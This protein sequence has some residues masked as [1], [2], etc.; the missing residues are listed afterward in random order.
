MAEI[1]QSAPAVAHTLLLPFDHCGSHL[2]DTTIEQSSR[3]QDSSA[4]T[5]PARSSKL[6]QPPTPYQPERAP[7]GRNKKKE[8]CW[9]ITGAEFQ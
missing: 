8:H 6:R 4:A 5:P 3:I 2:A 7:N 1:D 9:G